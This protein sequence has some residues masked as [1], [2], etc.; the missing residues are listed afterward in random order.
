MSTGP[1]FIICM[2]FFSDVIRCPGEFHKKKN[3]RN[4]G[5][6]MRCQ[7]WSPCVGRW[8]GSCG[9]TLNHSPL[10]LSL[11]HWG[12]RFLQIP[13]EEDV[14]YRENGIHSWPGDSTRGPRRKRRKGS[15]ASRG[16][17]TLF[18]KRQSSMDSG[19][20]RWGIAD[21]ESS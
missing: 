9:G 21:S 8:V 20:P 13:R 14:F 5:E 2:C 11:H 10:T 12:Q 19:N 1:Y 18:P 15:R 7:R 3:V 16:S 6:I 17:R 4:S